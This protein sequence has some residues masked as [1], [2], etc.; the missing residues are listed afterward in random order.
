MRIQTT[1]EELKTL[2][3]EEHNLS[4]NI[5]IEIIDVNIKCPTCVKKRM[6]EYSKKGNKIPAIKYLRELFNLGLSEAKSIADN[7]FSGDKTELLKYF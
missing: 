2:L 7:W 6:N 3:R 4:E 5:P 1:I